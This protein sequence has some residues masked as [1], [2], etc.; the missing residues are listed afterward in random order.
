MTGAGTIPAVTTV[1]ATT[2]VTTVTATTAVTTPKME[3]KQGLGVIGIGAAGSDAVDR[4]DGT[5]GQ[6]GLSGTSAV[7]MGTL[8]QTQLAMATHVEN[9]ARAAAVVD[10]QRERQQASLQ[11]CRVRMIMFRRAS[12]P[13]MV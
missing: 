1:T 6:T 9:E 10:T 8:A 7:D 4:A 12:H 3:R 13:G 11:V 5:L 2:A